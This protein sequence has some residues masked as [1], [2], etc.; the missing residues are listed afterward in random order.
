VQTAFSFAHSSNVAYRAG[1]LRDA[2]ADALTGWELAAQFGPAL[3]AWWYVAG[4]VLQALIAR[5]ELEFAEQLVEENALGEKRPAAISFP[6]T[7]ML[8]GELRIAQGRLDEGIADVLGAGAWAEGRAFHNP[9][10]MPWRAIAAPALAAVGRTEDAEALIDDGLSLARA[11]GRPWALG[12]TLRAAGLTRT[13]EA[14]LEAL[15]ES[16]A[17]LEQSQAR[18]ELARSLVEHGAALRRANQRAAARD[19][20]LRGL[21]LADRCGSPS[22]AR[23]AREELLTI[24]ARPRRDRVSGVDA[25]TAS[26]LR[27]ARLA[28]AGQ[29][30]RAIAQQLFVTTKTVEAHLARAYRKLDITSRA[31]LADALGAG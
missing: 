12:T 29:T 23:R 15:A 19:P 31:E 13:G 14:G 27:S 11:F 18:L 30:N 6:D 8:R 25:L 20:L 10:F 28:A 26:E 16:V 5:G 3:P 21:D 9:S 24:G 1:R 2:E 17:V 7:G 22:L 4:S